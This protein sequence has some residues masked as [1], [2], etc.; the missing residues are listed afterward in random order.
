[1]NIRYLSIWFRHL[2]TDGYALQ[3]PGLNNIPFVMASPEHGRMVIQAVNA[4]AEADGIH[5]GMVVAD[6]RVIFPSLQVVDAKE[7]MEEELLNLL[8]EWCLRYTPDVAIDLP[9]GLVLNI[10]G[11]PHLWGG[12]RAYLKDL[13][14]RLR[15]MGYDARAAIADTVGAAWAVARYGKI[16][17]LIEN[18]G[19]KETLVTLP[20][21]ALRLEQ[22]V[23]ERLHKLGL[24]TIG[25]FIDMPRSTLRRRFGPEILTRIDQALG[26]VAER[27]QPIRPMPPYEERLPCLEPIRTARGIEIAIS[28]L[29]EK[30]C[31]R[32]YREGKGLRTA[33]LTCHRIDHERQ[34]ISIST[35]RP[36]R[37]TEHLFKLFELQ[38]PTIKPALGIELFLLEA[39]I[40]ETL[41]ATQET[42]WNA[43]GSDEKAVAELLDK[44][45]GKV[46]A[47]KVHRYMPSEHYWPERSY[48]EAVSL[49]DQPATAWRTDRLRPVCLLPRPEKIE[50]S[51]P[52]PD[53]PPL[54]FRYG[55]KPYR[56]VKADGPERI[57][58][59]W[60]LEEGLHR[61]Y[62][63]VEDEGGARYWLFRSGHFD[64]EQSG[65]YLHGFFA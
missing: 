64:H 65:W 17:P 22:V 7:G 27:I 1:M 52:L 62:Y 30:L 13:V 61:D 36:S 20:P 8:A 43:T 33:I 24:Y 37:N 63:A 51:V 57:E 59:E 47:D 26:T 53:Y 45:A 28:R 39:G 48:K 10:T 14:L 54:L 60:W 40:T 3:Q 19:Q 38:I 50:V 16:T 18:G 58:Q 12:E 42:L 5:A 23:T 32:L 11:C 56:I 31:L 15:G 9:D 44:I 25:S 46:G 55:G 34:Q 35:G 21:A 2:L 49:Q 6:A 4:V 41:T 29:L